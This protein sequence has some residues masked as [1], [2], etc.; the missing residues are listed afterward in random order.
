M[1]QATYDVANIGHFG[2]ASKGYLHFTSPIRRYP[3]LVVHRIVHQVLEGKDALRGHRGE[4][5]REKLAEAALASSIA[6]RRAMEVERAIVDLYRTFLMKDRIGQRFEGTVTAVVGSGLF[7]QLD[8][9]YVDVLVR[10]E[11]LGHGHWEVDDDALRVVA[12][13]SGD[14]VAL[15]DRIAVEVIDASILRRTVYAKRVGGPQGD[16][17]RRPSQQRP[18]RRSPKGQKG[19]Q[20]GGD[21]RRLE[22]APRTDKKVMPNAAPGAK[23]KKKGRRR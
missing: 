14:V 3:D 16:E 4:P 22:R 8:S 19:A 6:E 20:R 11:D 13:R 10:L 15:G 2:L 18:E 17:Q 7:V 9:P 12:A 21:R 5:V 23:R 1:K